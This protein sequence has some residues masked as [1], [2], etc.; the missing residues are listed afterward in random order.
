[1]ALTDRKD[2]ALRRISELAAKATNNR[3][4]TPPP[5]SN[6][7]YLV[8]A[9]VAVPVIAGVAFVVSQV[10]RNRSTDEVADK[11]PAAFAPDDLDTGGGDAKV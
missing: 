5:R 3:I 11:N 8:L 2:A 1:M 6:R 10:L 4:G 9:A 7:T